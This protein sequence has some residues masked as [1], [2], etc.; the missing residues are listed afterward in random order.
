MPSFLPCIDLWIQCAVLRSS[1]WKVMLMALISQL[2]R[3]PEVILDEACRPAKPFLQDLA[4]VVLPGCQY[5]A[6]MNP[7]R[8]HLGTMIDFRPNASGAKFVYSLTEIL[9]LKLVLWIHDLI[10]IFKQCY[11]ICVKMDQSVIRGKHNT[12]IILPVYTMHWS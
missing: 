8:L 12:R 5:F 7:S 3:V 9:C 10:N 2:D 6:G 11:V 4:I 1:T